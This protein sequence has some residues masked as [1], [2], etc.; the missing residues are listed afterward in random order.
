MTLI[1]KHDLDIVKMYLDTEYEIPSYSGSKVR[2]QTDRH[3]N[4]HT[5]R[6]PHTQTDLTEISAD[7]L[8]RR[9][10]IMI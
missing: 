4:R 5:Y 3:T 8:A 7:P 1:L 9:V 6:Q 2:A 10:M